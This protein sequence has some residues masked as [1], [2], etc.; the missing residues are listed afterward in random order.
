MAKKEKAC[1][2]CRVIFQEEKCPIC[3]ETT[4]TENFKGRVYLFN[5][6][7]SQVAKNMKISEKGEFAIKTN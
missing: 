7:D 3:G 4:T 6:E 2:K 5:T 1:I